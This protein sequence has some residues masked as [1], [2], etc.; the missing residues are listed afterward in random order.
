[1]IMNGG[2][3]QEAADQDV[4]QWVQE[5]ETKAVGATVTDHEAAKAVVATKAAV[6]EAAKAVATEAAMVELVVLGAAV[7]PVVWDTG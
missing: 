7:E 2:A 3:Q 1:M 5:V 4:E 6:V